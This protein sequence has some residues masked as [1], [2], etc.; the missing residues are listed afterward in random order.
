[1]IHRATPT[2]TVS[3]MAPRRRARSDELW[4]G[5]RRPLRR[6][7]A[8]WIALGVAAVAVVIE[9]ALSSPS[10]PLGWLAFALIALAVVALIVTLNGILV[11][12]FRG[13]ADGWRANRAKPAVPRPTG[14]APAG[15]PRT[16]PERDDRGAAPRD[17]PAAPDPAG[18]SVSIPPLPDS[19]KNL[20]AAAQARK[21]TG[22]DV[23]RTARA[24]GR[25]AG[26]ARRA[27]R[28]DP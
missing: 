24:L 5:Y 6:D 25:A 22:Q 3:T 26:A 9:F 7:R 20:A 1:V 2:A 21:P 23:D 19:V 4:R 13:F 14:A 27:Y 12:V 15:S 18:P 10:T 11:G 17:E 28:K 8:L 16:D